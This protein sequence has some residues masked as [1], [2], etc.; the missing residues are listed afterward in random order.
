MTQFDFAT[1]KDALLF[2]KTYQYAKTL[3]CGAKNKKNNTEF[4][5]L[6]NEKIA[7]VKTVPNKE[8]IDKD[9][10]LVGLFAPINDD[11]PYTFKIVLRGHKD[12]PAD[13]ETLLKHTFLHEVLHAAI[14]VANNM[15]KANKPILAKTNGKSI[16]FVNYEGEIVEDNRKTGKINTYGNMVNEVVIN[17]LATATLGNLDSSYKD[18]KIT[19]DRVFANKSLNCPNFE[20]GYTN[21]TSLISLEL[22]AFSNNCEVKYQKLFADKTSIG[23]AKIKTKK[24]TLLY[25]NDLVYGVMYNP[26]HIQE[27]FDKYMGNG[28]YKKFAKKQDHLLD[29]YLTNDQKFNSNDKLNIKSLIKTTTNFFNA[30]ISSY[31]Q[32][33][34][35]SY[36]EIDKLVDHYNDILVSVQ[37]EYGIRFSDNNKN[38]K[39]LGVST[40]KI[41]EKNKK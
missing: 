1:K 5:N 28:A 31:Y 34:V 41:L 19:F 12:A 4:S 22:A 9:E 30:K 10:I 33:K 32:N 2:K 6:F 36:D 39:K 11:T 18:K 40:G 24:D 20:N 25:A 23:K 8:V 3:F 35:M 7:L 15:D 14:E 38:N 17:M 27:E 16:C 13:K 26:Y 21:L 29:H 37:E